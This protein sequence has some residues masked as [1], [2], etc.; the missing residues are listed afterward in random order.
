MQDLEALRVALGVER[1]AIAGGDYGSYVALRYAQAY[2]DRVERLL[3]ESAI[4]REGVGTR[5]LATYP[6]ITSART[7]TS[8]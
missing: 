8:S 4:P 7:P 1:L 5:L 3:L 6:A 2:P